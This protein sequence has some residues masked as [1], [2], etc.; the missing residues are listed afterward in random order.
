MTFKEYLKVHRLGKNL[1]QIE[2]AKLLGTSQA[3][4]SRVESGTTKPGIKFIRKI[5]K[6]YNIK[7]ST[8][9]KLLNDN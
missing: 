5:A 8:L 6:F 3:Y 1:S 2:M 9:R 7:E 4:Y